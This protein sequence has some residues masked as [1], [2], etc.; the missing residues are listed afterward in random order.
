V[1]SHYAWELHDEGVD[2]VLDNVQGMAGANAVYLVGLMHP[3]I[4]PTTSPAFPHNPVRQTWIAEDS[5]VYWRPDRSLYGRIGPRQSEHAFLHETDWLAVLIEAARKRGLAT[6]VEISHTIL[7][8]DRANGELADCVQRDIHGR[9]CQQ[10]RSPTA[11]AQYLAPFCPNNA[12]ARAYF[13]ALF[14]DVARYDVDFVQSCTIP[15][16]RGTPAT[17]GCWCPACA[18]AAEKEG[19]DFARLRATLL[20]DPGDRDATETWQEFRYR[21]VDRLWAEVAATLGAARPGTELRYNLYEYANDDPYPDE[22]SWGLRL[23]TMGRNLGS[24]R[25]NEYAEQRGDPAQMAVKRRWIEHVKSMTPPELP[26]L[27]AVA[28]RP[29]ATPELIRQGVRMAVETG[30]VGISLGHYDGSEWPMLHAVREGLAE[31]DVTI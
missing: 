15:F 29:K 14:R 4:R 19:I 16:D 1:T 7:G 11:P 31:A 27:T 22:L 2:A 25:I 9:I 18:T 12:D 3:E 24:L 8:T 5:R 6:G 20:A 26:L 13:L 10:H 30:M 17:G 28:V 21:S 23:R